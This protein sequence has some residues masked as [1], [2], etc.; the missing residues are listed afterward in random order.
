MHHLLDT[1]LL[2][3]REASDKYRTELV[4]ILADGGGAGELEESMMWYAWNYE[5]L[6]SDA[7]TEEQEEKWKRSWLD[8]LEQKE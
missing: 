4:Q 8:R 5:K 6:P 7:P 3:S 2:R 1:I